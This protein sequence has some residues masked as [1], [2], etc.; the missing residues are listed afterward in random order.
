MANNPRDVIVVGGGIVGSLTAYLLARQGLKVTV[1]EGDAV[2]SHASGFAFGEMGPLEGAGIPEPLL[3]FSVWSLRQHQ[4]LAAELKE[5]SGVDHQFQICETLKL[6][7]DEASV[8]AYKED[9]SWQKQVAGFQVQWLSSEEVVKV[10]PMANPDSL[11]AVHVQ[12][13]ASVEPYQYTL[14]ASQAGERAGV[15]ILLR[16]VTGLIFNAD[17]CSG[18]TFEGGHLEAGTV[19]LAMGPW[20]G[21]ASS[22]CRF[23]IPVAPLKGQILRLKHSGA[24]IK[25][26]LHWRGGYVI[27]KPDGLVWAGTTEEE[28]GFDEQPTTEARDKIMGNLL[29]M[30]PSLSEA[31]LVRQTACLRPLS[32]DGLPIVG[33]VPGWTNLFVGTGTGRKGILWSTGMSLRFERL[34]RQGPLPGAGNRVPRPGAVFGRLG[35]NYAETS[36]VSVQV[37]GSGIDKCSSRIPSM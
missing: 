22:W 9:L 26:S 7:F 12:G 32:V 31:Q 14:S 6:A 33:K 21:D 28:V 11:G 5:A 35:W 27:T 2:G 23:N 1:L 37:P 34:D 13:I 16:R 24:A 30:A 20:S 10:E 29:K 17:R 8:L 25:T 19:V 36:T 3:E 4:S 18:V 15:E